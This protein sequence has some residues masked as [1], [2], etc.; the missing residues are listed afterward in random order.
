MQWF[1]IFHQLANLFLLCC[2]LFCHKQKEYNTGARRMISWR[3]KNASQ[4]L[5]N[6][7]P[8]NWTLFYFE[9]FLIT[10]M[11]S[12]GLLIGNY[13]ILCLVSIFRILNE[14]GCTPFQYYFQYF[15]LIHRFCLLFGV[16]S[17]NM[18]LLLTDCWINTIVKLQ[19]IT[20]CSIS[21][22]ISNEL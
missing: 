8:I 5:D 2:S 9:P 15:V 12:Y 1:W 20:F 14:V 11:N 18:K 22:K 13:L 6:W 10:K 17:E 3:C 7:K 21:L 19:Q 4:R 16:G